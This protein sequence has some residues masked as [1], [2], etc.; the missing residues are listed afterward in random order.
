VIDEI[1]YSNSK[2]TGTPEEVVLK[3]ISRV[4]KKA[5]NSIA[6]FLHFG[7]KKNDSENKEFAEEKKS[8]VVPITVEI[9]EMNNNDPEEIEKVIEEIQ[10]KQKQKPKTKGGKASNTIINKF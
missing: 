2:K 10:N 3:K 9:V 5:K 6:S 7:H 8:E 4:V 1:I